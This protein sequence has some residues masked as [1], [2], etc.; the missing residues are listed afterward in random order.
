MKKFLA[1]FMVMILIAQMPLI[2]LAEEA[3]ATPEVIVTPAPSEVPTATFAPAEAATA[4]PKAPVKATE[5]VEPTTTAESAVEPTN[6]VMPSATVTAENIGEPADTASPEATDTATPTDTA[7]DE[8]T[9]TATLEPTVTPTLVPISGSTLE[10]ALPLTLGNIQR[11]TLTEEATTLYYTFDTDVYSSVTITTGGDSVSVNLLKANGSLLAELATV[12]GIVDETQAVSAGTSYALTVSGAADASFTLLVE[13]V[14]EVETNALAICEGDAEPRVFAG[15]TALT[16]NS[17]LVTSSLYY[18]SDTDQRMQAIYYVTLPSAG[19]MTAYFNP[20][21]TAEMQIWDEALTVMYA[22]VGATGN[23][24]VKKGLWLEAGNYHIILKQTT[25]ITNAYTIRT[26]FSAANNAIGGANSTLTAYSL[27]ASGDDTIGVFTEQDR[28]DVLIFAASTPSKVT[29]DTRTYA[30][31]TTLKI[32]SANDTKYYK[33]WTLT[34]GN[35]GA[36]SN[37]IWVE[38]G[39]YY[40]YVSAASSTGTY[41]IRLSLNPA[42]NTETEPNNGIGTAMPIRLDSGSHRGLLSLQ[43][44]IDCYSVTPTVDRD[45]EISVSD[46]TNGL[47]INVYGG[48]TLLLDLSKSGTGG[49]EASAYEHK[50]VI[51]MYAG[52]TYYIVIELNANFGIYDLKV[53]S[54]LSVESVTAS[55]TR[56]AL[57]GYIS[58]TTVVSER[59]SVVAG[60]YYIYKKSGSTYTLVSTHP[61]TGSTFGFKPSAI[62]TYR[63]S[64]YVYD[65]YYWAGCDSADIVIEDAVSVSNVALP[66]SAVGGTTISGV[67]TTA[68]ADVLLYA[69]EV[70]SVSG[71]Q[72]AGRTTA[73]TNSFSFKINASGLYYMIV[74]VYDGVNWAYGVSNYIQVTNTLLITS[75]TPDRPSTTIGNNITFTM[76]TNGGDLYFTNYRVYC[77]GTLIN[78]ITKT[79]GALTTFVYKPQASGT[80]TVLGAG[81]DG[82]K[83]VGVSSPSVEVSESLHLYALNNS[84]GAVSLGETITFALTANATPSTLVYR[85]LDTTGAIVQ[86]YTTS[87]EMSHTFTLSKAGIFV[88][89]ALAYD[90]GAWQVVS[91]GWFTVSGSGFSITSVT[92]ATGI[93]TVGSDVRI[94]LTTKGVATTFTR[95]IVVDASG[96]RVTSW[97]GNTHTFYFKPTVK[98]TYFV[99]VVASEGTTYESAISPWFTVQ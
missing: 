98:G 86:T 9:D 93:H 36:N 87:S 46:Y 95:Y 72:V 74:Y 53:S 78:S 35:P 43:D 38:S 67:V 63:V 4:E 24:I 89:V 2:V 13:G 12:N 51:R 30:S 18:T 1:I 8:A 19:Q 69:Y 45:V 71:N 84:S 75:L 16:L 5:T 42:N 76:A 3:T 27:S 94:T 6:T 64:Y 52:A 59:S 88:G 96:N 39:S 81:Y 99:Y 11:N 55:P 97:D 15:A 26:T 28:T 77:D 68:G 70:Y 56:A 57:G 60:I 40:L 20:T 80:Y 92:V 23:A 83:W 22:S 65:G 47:T 50:G 79:S 14:V 21:Y 49:S 82:A 85:I 37:S 34:D 54:R 41:T 10:L 58:T 61:S 66:A 33:E 32:I 25:Q 17:S 48:S 31:G 44:N 29:I 62:G 73:Y 90:A 7:T 91:S